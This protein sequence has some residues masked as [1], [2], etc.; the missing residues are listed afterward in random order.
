MYCLLFNLDMELL[1]EKQYREL[2]IDSYSTLKVFI[3]DR[4]RYYRKF[5][6]KD[7]LPED[8]TPYT[9]FGSLVDCLVFKPEEFEDKF[10]LAVTQPPTGQYGKFVEQ[11]MKVTLRSINS[12]GEVTRDLEDMMLDAYNEVKF[13]KD[14]NVV[15]FKR[16]SF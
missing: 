10:A 15:D 3:E 14:H 16:D 8:E 13:D 12:R 6:L 5:V 11:L 7:P 4:K 9:I 1:S 2:E